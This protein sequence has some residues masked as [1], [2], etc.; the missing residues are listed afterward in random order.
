[1]AYIGI[2]DCKKHHMT[3][4]PCLAI[5][6]EGTQMPLSR[7]PS[8]YP[9]NTGVCE[10]MRVHLKVS[11]DLMELLAQTDYVVPFKNYG[12]VKKKFDINQ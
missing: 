5:N 10:C 7:C 1:M 3:G 8:C 11:R 2:K 6:L 12:L 9:T 4:H